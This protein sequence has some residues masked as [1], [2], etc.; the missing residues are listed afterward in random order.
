MS[1]AAQDKQLQFLKR[2]AKGLPSMLA[3]WDA[4]QR[5]RYANDAYE[6]WFGVSPGELIGRHIKELLGPELYALNTPHIDAALSGTPQRFERVIVLPGGET[7]NS[8]AHYVPDVVDGVVQGFG[9][10]VIDVTPIKRAEAAWQAETAARERTLNQL[11]RSEEALRRAQRLGQIGSWEWEIDVDIVTWSE[12]L[13]KLFELDPS[14]LPPTYA[15]HAKLYE[16]RSWETLQRAV[17]KT[18]STGEPF[19]IELQFCGA[20]GRAGWLEGR[21]EAVKDEEGRI[22]RLMGTTQVVTERR[23]L[24]QLRLERTRNAVALQQRDALTRTLSDGIRSAVDSI[25]SL[26]YLLHTSQLTEQQHDWL[27]TIADCGAQIELLLNELDHPVPPLIEACRTVPSL[28]ARAGV[29]DSLEASFDLSSDARYRAFFEQDSQFAGFLN[30]NGVLL[31]AN[32]SSLHAGGYTREQVIGLQFWQCAWFRLSE[33]VI[34]T[35]RQAVEAAAAGVPSTQEIQF[36]LASGA[37][38]VARL[39]LFTVY[40]DSGAPRF[41]AAT[42][43][44]ITT[45]KAVERELVELADTAEHIVRIDRKKTEFLPVVAHELR[46]V[47]APVALRLAVLEKSGNL[48]PQ[49]LADVATMRRQTRQIANLI[50]DLL[51]ASNISRGTFSLTLER[52]DLRLALGDA[53]ANCVAAI[54]LARQELAQCLPDEPVWVRADRLR[55]VQVFTNLLGNATKYTPYG[56]HIELS[57]QTQEGWAVVT[58]VDSGTGLE[59]GTIDSIFGLFEQVDATKDSSQG[60]LGI[61]LSVVRRLVEKHGGT[62]SAASAGPGMGSAFEVRLPR[63]SAADGLA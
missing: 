35:V 59:A 11:R 56:G 43:T 44:D 36:F 8:L 41:I 17:S 19:C 12:E 28:L 10:E 23:A 24:H 31:E 37:Q 39:T 53:V 29:R 22:V 6:Q 38:R 15:D 18:L 46:N 47:L 2:V 3:Y 60:G 61:G 7:K 25:G 9:V 40:D 55:L 62:V 52:L 63:D 42:G 27:R 5:C 20:K 58:V 21:G 45:Q 26:A 32:T 33:D 1:A 48:A 13:Y 30:L 34:R 4:G 49:L 51:D 57:A 16:P 50:E 54:T 14:R